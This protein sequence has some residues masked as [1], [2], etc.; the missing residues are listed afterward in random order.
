MN[1]K[2]LKPHKTR[3]YI[4][5]I[6]LF[7]LVV[8]TSIVAKAQ[9]LKLSEL[10][11][12][13]AVLQ[14]NSKVCIWGKSK[15][16][17]KVTLQIQERQFES[18]SDKNGHWSLNI[19]PLK[20]GG[21]YSM[22]VVSAKDTIQIKEIYVGEVWLAGG[23]SNMQLKLKSAE[24]GKEEVE[25]ANNTNIHFLKVPYLPYEGAPIIGDMNWHNATS[26]NVGE[27][28]AVAYY[29]AKDLQGKLK[30]PIGIICCYRGGSHAECWVNRETLLKHAETK[31]IINEYDLYMSH[32]DSIVFQKKYATYLVDLKKSQDSS[33]AGLKV[34]RSVQEPMSD[35]NYNRPGGLYQTMFK[36]VIPYSIKGVIWYQGESNTQNAYQYRTLLPAL[37]E[38]WRYDFNNTLMPFILVQLPGYESPGSYD[39]QRWPELREAQ[40]MTSQKIKN[41]G[42]A[43]T[44]DLGDKNNIHPKNKKPVGERLA[45]VAINKVYGIN[46]PYSGPVFK[47]VKFNKN[48]AIIYFDFT[49]NGLQSEGELK[50]FT[51]CGMDKKFFSAKAIIKNKKVIVWTD[52]VVNPIAI[53]YG[54]SDWSESNLK[55][56]DGFPASPFRTNKFEF[57]TK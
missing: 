19:S 37:I 40:L 4:I 56:G 11:N 28:S 30:V 17:S 57:L 14:R 9:Q 22:K 36:R 12:E 55:N 10:F 16:L 2:I 21:P 25:K 3:K 53:R 34:K 39:R 7:V 23:Q 44:I 46:K 43:V 20:S 49:H 13:G 15:P 1:K 41:T 32:F 38:N 8:L 5:Q 29:F 33:K 45:A 54:W 42:M 24:N 47:N 51:I 27:M 48:Q 6:S 35:K 50:G 31:S 18:I 26:E 52:S